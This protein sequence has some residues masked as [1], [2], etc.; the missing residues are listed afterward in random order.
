MEA[1]VTAILTRCR[2]CKLERV[3]PRNPDVDL[4]AYVDATKDEVPNGDRAFVPCIVTQRQLNLHD[5][6]RTWGVP[7]FG[8]G[9]VVAKSDEAVTVRWRDPVEGDG[10]TT[11]PQEKY[12]GHFLRI[13]EDL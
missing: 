9:L 4:Q 11:Y 1:T 13:E 6:V 12:A 10:E 8:F 5:V 3:A 2:A 7:P